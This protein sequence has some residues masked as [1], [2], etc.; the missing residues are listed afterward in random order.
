MIL[1]D[2]RGNQSGAAA[3]TTESASDGGAEIGVGGCSHGRAANAEHGRM[4]EW[5]AFRDGARGYARTMV[6]AVAEKSLG[7]QF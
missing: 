7:C 6:A 1:N 2:G 3:S 4:S 5:V